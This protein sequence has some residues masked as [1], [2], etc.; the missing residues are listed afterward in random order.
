MC[1]FWWYVHNA[2]TKDPNMYFPTPPLCFAL[3]TS[4]TYYMHP[5]IHYILSNTTYVQ[6]KYCFYSIRSKRGLVLLHH[7][8]WSNSILV[9]HTQFWLNFTRKN[10]NANIQKFKILTRRSTLSFTWIANSPWFRNHSD[11][12]EICTI[13]CFERH[14]KPIFRAIHPK[15][16]G[17]RANAKK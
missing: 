1:W 17:E 15:L 8:A 2:E 10:R 7:V 5:V 9:L 14:L 13:L 6:H 11:S 4:L 12:Q 16:K 3:S